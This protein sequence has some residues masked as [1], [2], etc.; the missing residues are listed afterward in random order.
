MLISVVQYCAVLFSVNQCY[1]L[2]IKNL[3]NSGG[4]I[5]YLEPFVVALNSK[6]TNYTG[7]VRGSYSSA[8]LN[9]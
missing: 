8:Q 9:K 5:L 7:G 2:W 3:T 1:A 6:S 4:V